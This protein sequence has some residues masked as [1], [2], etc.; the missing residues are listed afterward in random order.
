MTPDEM[1]KSPSDPH[2]ILKEGPTNATRQSI[3]LQI[4][5]VETRPMMSSTRKSKYVKLNKA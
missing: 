4:L 1:N 2:R 3:Q 5:P